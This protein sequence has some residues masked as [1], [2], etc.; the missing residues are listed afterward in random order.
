MRGVAAQLIEGTPSSEPLT[1]TDMVAPITEV[2]SGDG[3][4]GFH[5]S[6]QPQTASIAQCVAAQ[7]PQYASII[8]ERLLARDP[9]DLSRRQCSL[10]DFT[11][12]IN[13]DTVRNTSRKRHAT[14]HEDYRNHPR[15]RR[16]PEW[17]WWYPRP[18]D[19]ILT[20]RAMCT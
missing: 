4:M 16:H 7:C 8:T 2:S 6:M 18:D 14:A 19:P 17:I 13:D 1:P 11:S 15:S 10:P 20:A 5:E 9:G 3:V 12:A